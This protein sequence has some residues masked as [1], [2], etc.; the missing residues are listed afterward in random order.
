MAPRLAKTMTTGIIG[1]GRMA[2]GGSAVKEAAIGEISS[3]D[4]RNTDDLDFILLVATKI[5]IRLKIVT[6]KVNRF[7]PGIENWYWAPWDW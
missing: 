4:S 7:L 6:G 2:W 5:P 3:H 1:F